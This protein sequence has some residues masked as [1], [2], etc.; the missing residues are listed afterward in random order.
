ML[1][2]SVLYGLLTQKLHAEKSKIG[3]EVLHGTRKWR[4]NFQF[5]RSK[6]KV[7]GPKNL[8]NLASPHLYLQAAAP[9]NQV[10]QAPTAQQAY[11]IVR[12]TLLSALETLGN[13]TEGGTMSL[14]TSRFTRNNINICK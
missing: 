13:G 14:Q 4:A 3:M 11:A 9:A 2:P 6:V 10:R 12:P 8:K 5:E 1:L 7:T